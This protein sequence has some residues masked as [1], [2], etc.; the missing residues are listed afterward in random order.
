MNEDDLW[1]AAGQIDGDGSVGA[2]GGPATGHGDGILAVSVGKAENSLH[3]LKHLQSLFRGRIQKNRDSR[4]NLQATFSWV[5]TGQEAVKFCNLIRDYVQLKRPQFQLASSWDARPLKGKPFVLIH[6]S[7]ESIYYDSLTALWKDSRFQ[8]TVRQAQKCVLKQVYP[9]SLSDKEWMAVL[10]DKREISKAKKAI[11]NLLVDLKRT[12]HAKI[13]RKLPAAYFA[14]IFDAEGTVCTHGLN[15]V[16][17][18]VSQKYKAICDCFLQHYAGG[19]TQSER[20]FVWSVS[21]RKDAFSFIEDILPYSREKKPQLELVLNMPVNRAQQVAK[22]LRKYK[23]NQ[24]REPVERELRTPVKRLHGLPQYIQEKKKEGVVTGY[25]VVFKGKSRNFASPNIELERKLELAQ[26]CLAELKIDHEKS[27]VL[28]D[29]E[30]SELPKFI[31]YKKR[32][33]KIIGLRVTHKNGQATFED[34][35]KPLKEHLKDAKIFLSSL[36]NRTPNN[37]MRPCND[38]FTTK[39][40]KDHWKKKIL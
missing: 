7:E 26:E 33:G 13:D 5:L 31:H 23:G 9:E 8:L 15:G 29:T 32:E 1:Y 19:L 6:P 12:P 20:L 39:K 25:L 16:Q 22:E 40:R 18:S 34:N 38:P 14:G 30:I 27:Q 10:I 17:V 24:G 2:Y 37:I 11:R 21:N 3:V 28:Q 36:L 4:Q 35:E